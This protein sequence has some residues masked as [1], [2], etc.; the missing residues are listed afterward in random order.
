MLTSIYN[1]YC[2][3]FL[4]QFQDLLCWKRINKD[5]CLCYFQVSRLVTLGSD[6]IRHFF[7]HQFVSSLSITSNGSGLSD[8]QF[9]CKV[10]TEFN[11]FLKEQQSNNNTWISTCANLLEISYDFLEF[12]TAYRVGDAID[13]ECNYQKH[14]S[15]WQ[16]IGQHKYIDIFFVRQEYIFHN[17]PFSLL[18][19][20][21]RSMV[22]RRY[23]DNAGKRCV[24][25]NEF[26]E[27]GIRVF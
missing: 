3:G 22:V 13:I 8:A 10:A 4:D 24:A 5:I 2:T 25:H 12:V 1:L 18:Q 27:H 6:E 17:N 16:A 21:R 15:I 9:I 11:Q 20:I 14:S 26:L 19:E 23:H 7:N